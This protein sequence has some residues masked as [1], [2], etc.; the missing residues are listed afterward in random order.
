M[1]SLENINLTILSKQN[2]DKSFTSISFPPSNEE[3][4]REECIR[5]AVFRCMNFSSKFNYLCEL[6]NKKYP[7]KE[8]VMANLKSAKY[9]RDHH[10]SGHI[11]YHPENEALLE[12]AFMYF[13]CQEIMVQEHSLQDVE[14]NIER[15]N[16]EIVKGKVVKDSCLL[17]NHKY[18]CLSVYVSFN[19]NDNDDAFDENFDN[20]RYKWILLENKYSNSLNRIKKGLIELNPEIFTKEIIFKIKQ[21]PEW[22]N[23]ERELWK[24]KI[25]ENLKKYNLNFSF[26]YTN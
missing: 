19:I 23:L 5:S 20:V 11:L 1:N 8:L 14:V 21:H 26:I 3:K 13:E 15:S 12:E 10:C 9:I 17:Y 24:K 2:M 7:E 22:L 6:T 4:T 25:E 16:K 18:D